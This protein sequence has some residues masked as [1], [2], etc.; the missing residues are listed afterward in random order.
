M[1]LIQEK[2]VLDQNPALVSGQG[3]SLTAD[4]MD[5]EHEEEYFNADGEGNAWSDDDA[6]A[7]RKVDNCTIS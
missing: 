2:K 5:C 7:N 4:C 1:G 3:E 6:I